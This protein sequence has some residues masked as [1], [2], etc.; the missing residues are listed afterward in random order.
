MLCFIAALVAM[1]GIQLIFT[2]IFALYLYIT[3]SNFAY[4]YKYERIY[5]IFVCIIT[6]CAQFLFFAYSVDLIK[7]HIGH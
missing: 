2:S 7:R 5:M 3:I 6:F 4:M 1:I